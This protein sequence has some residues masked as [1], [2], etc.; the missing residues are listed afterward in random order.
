MDVIVVLNSPRVWRSLTSISSSSLNVRSDP[1]V[2]GRGMIDR[3]VTEGCFP[4]MACPNG[5]LVWERAWGKILECAGSVS[6]LDWTDSWKLAWP[7]V[8]VGIV[9]GMSW[10]K[11]LKGGGGSVSGTGV[12]N[13]G[14]VG[15]VGLDL[16]PGVGWG[17]LLIC[18]LGRGLR[19]ERVV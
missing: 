7:W 11:L 16:N 6:D 4:S 19:K 10:W 14:W 3:G 1:D 17:K 5:V 8:W 13:W 9:W 2:K 12:G 18:L 15:L